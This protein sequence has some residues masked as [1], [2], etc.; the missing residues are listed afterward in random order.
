[1]TSTIKPL[2]TDADYR[3]ALERIAVLMELEDELSILSVLV[4]AWEA[5]HF[6]TSPPDPIE[7]IKFRMEQQNLK[8][9]DLVPYIGSRSKVSEVLAGKRNL[10][11]AMRI[12]LHRDLGIPASSLL[13]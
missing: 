8:Q 6:P 3:A 10:S 4:A 13:Q 7:A 1:M 2:K 9:A 12:R 11:L 5:E